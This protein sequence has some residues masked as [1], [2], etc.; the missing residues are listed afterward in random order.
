[1]L[2]PF[3]LLLLGLIGAAMATLTALLIKWAAEAH[4]VTAA[5]LVLFLL[6]MMIAMLGG[7]LLYFLHPG[8]AGLVDGLWLASGAMSVLVFPVV[9]VYLKDAQRHFRLKERYVPTPLQRRAT[10]ALGILG[11]VVLNEFLMGWTFQLAAG[12]LAVSSARSVVD[13]LVL[14]VNSPWFLFPMALEMGLSAYFL[15]RRLPTPFVG[16]LL[17]QAGLMFLSP[18]AFAGSP[19]VDPTLALGSVVMIGLVVFVFERLYRHRQ[20][21][22]VL[23]RYYLLLFSVYA[24]M[25]AGLYVWLVY[26]DGLAFALSI[27]FEMALFFDAVVQPERFEA[28]AGPP[29]TLRPNWTFGVLAMVFIAELFMGAVLNLALEPAQWVGAIPTLALS[30]PPL[31]VLAHA[32][33]NGFWFFALTAGSTWYLAMMG[34]EMGMLVVFKFRETRSGET[35]LRLGLML[36]SYAAF[37]VWFPSVYY[38]QLLPHAPSGTSVPLLGWSMGIGSAALAPAVF[39]AVLGTYVLTAVLSVL[40]G[41]RWLCSTF[42]SAPLMFQGTTIDAMSS[43][44]RSSPLARRYLSSRFSGAYSATLGVVMTSLVGLSVLSYSNTAGL[45]DVRILG[46]DP[47]VFLYV[48]SFNV[49]WYVLFVTIPYTGNYNCVTLGWCYTG[50]IAQA[51][52]KVGFYSLRVKDREVCRRCTT[53][54]CA[55]KCPVGLVD[56][57]GHFRTKGVFRS[58]K[59][60]GVGDCVEA[61]P[62]DNIYFHDVRHWLRARRT[63]VPV[64]E[65]ARLPMVGTPSPAATAREGTATTR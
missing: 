3:L 15:R 20:M 58:S 16:M 39:G 8:T 62:Y 61:C 24:L 40:F 42:C 30:G 23:S 21:A 17:A 6:G 29:W 13:V 2:S 60:C 12:T 5:G 10:F 11:L 50:I 7:A 65:K 45:T 41:R 35:R 32:F 38:S 26:G 22:P 64:K 51:F 18:P 34:A 36:A 33:E 25:M 4:T 14:G 48:L 37:V 28:A 63:P 9:Y 1:V 52:Q 46:L 49:M 59:C 54:D 57:P 55:K 44:N 53:L 47:T 31:T 19:L 27:L 43:F 56:M